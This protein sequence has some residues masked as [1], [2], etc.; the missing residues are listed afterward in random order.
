[1]AMIYMN[2]FEWNSIYENISR[3][4]IYS[5]NASGVSTT[6]KRSGNYSF[7]MHDQYGYSDYIS[8][9][10]PPVSEFYIQFCINVRWVSGE[11]VFLRWFEGST[12]GGVITL[13]NADLKLRVYE[14]NKSSLLCTSGTALVQERWYLIELYVK[15]DSSGEIELRVN[16]VTDTTYS[17]DTTSYSIDKFTFGT[18]LAYGQSMTYYVDDIVIN[19]T[20]GSV[21]NSWPNGLRILL[22]K[23]TGKGSSSEWTKEPE[24]N[25]DNYWCVDHE[26]IDDPSEYA[27]TFQDLK[28]DLYRVE[29]LPA[30]AYSVAA[31]RVDSWSLKN[32]GSRQQINLALKPAGATTFYSSDQ[33]LGIAFQLKQNTWETNPSTSADWS[34]SEINNLEVGM[35]SKFP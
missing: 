27:Y 26:P 32:S 30:T 22:L 13:S 19:D 1:M 18:G 29:N 7:Y 31:A 24:D 14:G 16:G 11:A 5:I 15:H 9:P 4:Y 28:L 6:H 8:L 33:D 25:I 10:T 23:P 2:G 21:N 34:I 3:Y 35:R 20:T 17:G 12:Y